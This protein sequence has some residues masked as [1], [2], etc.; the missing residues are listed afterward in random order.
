MQP[1]GA[2]MTGASRD[3][4]HQKINLFRIGEARELCFNY[5]HRKRRLPCGSSLVGAGITIKVRISNIF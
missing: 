4:W 3:I 1:K 5:S 2:G